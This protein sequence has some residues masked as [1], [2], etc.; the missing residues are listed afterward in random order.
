MDYKYN[1]IILNKFDIGE[2]D[3][4]YGI[5]TLEAGKIRVRAIGVKKPNAKL[6]GSLEP[7]TQS[8]IFMA[9]G[10][11]RG[12]ITGAIAINNF[13][14]IKSDISA[15]QKVFYTFGIFNRLITDE[16]KDENLFRLI[17]KYLETI[18]ELSHR[19]KDIKMDIVTSGFLVRL[20]ENMGYKIEAEKCVKC[21]ERLKP[22]GNF[23]SA[24]RGGILCGTCEKQ[25]LKKVKIGHNTV[26]IIRL[27]LA[28]KIENFA[29]IEA[30]EKTVKNLKLVINEEINWITG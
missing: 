15:I 20:L 1:G 29:K 12:N 27:F 24:E 25:I 3:R 5:Y 8:E 30:E 14:E 23:F 11:G 13:L 17:L 28:N 21:G 19:E 10:R 7:L 9:R 4:L 18:N 16:E 22:D 2:T 6:A 26:K